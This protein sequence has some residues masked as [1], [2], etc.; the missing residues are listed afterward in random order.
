M[1][2]DS[3]QSLK[4]H[5]AFTQEVTESQTVW[6]L[7]DSQGFATCF[8]NQFS[9]EHNKS[10]QLICFWSS[11]KAA[12][13]CAKEDWALYQPE[14]ITL[15]D[16]LEFWCTGMHNDGLLVGSNFDW[17]MF[18]HEIEPLEIAFEIIKALKGKQLALSFQNFGD[19]EELEQFILPAFED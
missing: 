13:V 19:L 1:L 12:K 5:R 16:F 11:E 6:G 7:K 4:R 8:S 14:A 15:A 9:D 3:I 2:K 10:V 18:G 17:N